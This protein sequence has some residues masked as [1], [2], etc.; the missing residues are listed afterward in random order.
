MVSGYDVNFTSSLGRRGRE[1]VPNTVVR[2]APAVVRQARERSLGVRGARMFNLLPDS[3]R[4]IDTDHVDF[5]KNHLDVFLSS[6]PDQP[7]VIGQGRAAVSNSL[8]DQLPMFY[9]M[10]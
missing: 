3:I 2:A 7:T 5:F 8:L 1:I 4:N 6:V 9:T 10:T